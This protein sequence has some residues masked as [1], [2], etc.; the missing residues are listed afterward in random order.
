MFIRSML[1]ARTGTEMNRGPDLAQIWQTG[2][3]RLNAVAG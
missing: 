2:V 3:D 1:T